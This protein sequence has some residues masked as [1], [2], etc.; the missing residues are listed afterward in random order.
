MFWKQYA[1]GAVVQWPISGSP[2]SVSLK[3]FECNAPD[4]A[5]ILASNSYTSLTHNKIKRTRNIKYRNIQRF[6]L[7]SV[8]STYKIP[9]ERVTCTDKH[10]DSSR[11]TDPTIVRVGTCARYLM[12]PILNALL[13][14]LLKLLL[15]FTQL[16]ESRLK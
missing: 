3:L 7:R 9:P 14:I 13:V 12:P 15:R 1:A 2:H 4:S 6:L 8:Q 5:H 16:L 11:F 10:N